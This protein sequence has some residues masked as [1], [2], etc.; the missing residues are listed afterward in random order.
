MTREQCC[1]LPPFLFSQRAPGAGGWASF[2]QLSLGTL[3][4]PERILTQ[5]FRTKRFFLTVICFYA[6]KLKGFHVV[7]VLFFPSTPL[8]IK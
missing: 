6:A 4:I 2:L 3:F 1:N 5:I 8:K 7:R